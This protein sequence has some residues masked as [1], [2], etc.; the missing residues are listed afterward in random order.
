MDIVLQIIGFC[1]IAYLALRFAPDILSAVFK[2]SVIAI[3]LLLVLFA[4]SLY[5]SDWFW[6][7]HYA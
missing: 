4:V 3:A 6:S 7:V 5:M 2:L 1:A